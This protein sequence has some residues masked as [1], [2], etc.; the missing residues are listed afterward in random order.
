MLMRNVAVALLVIIQF[1]AVNSEAES[2]ADAE[3]GKS[4]YEQKC[5]ACHSVDANSTGPRHRGVFGRRA[6][7][8]EDYRYS[9]AL[10]DQDFDWNDQTLDAWLADPSAVVP[11]N[12]MG[13]AIRSAQ[14][15]RDLIAYLRTL[16]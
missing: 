15:R 11:G 13:M 5:K 3:R 9:L 4:L 8:L 14:E 7:T 12:L 6:G 10:E 16:K 2:P 1:A